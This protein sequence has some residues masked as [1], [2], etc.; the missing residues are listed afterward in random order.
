[1]SHLAS[2]HNSGH[3]DCQQTSIREC[4]RLLNSVTAV[5]VLSTSDRR[6]GCQKMNILNENGGRDLLL[7]APRSEHCGFQSDELSESKLERLK[8]KSPKSHFELNRPLITSGRC[9]IYRTERDRPPSSAIIMSILSISHSRRTCKICI[10]CRARGFLD[11][12]AFDPC[13]LAVAN[14]KDVCY[15]CAVRLIFLNFEVVSHEP[16]RREAGKGR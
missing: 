13:E 7:P 16:A 2:W 10:C 6:R 15:L 4:R 9:I 8:T 5:G 12:K 1:M 11:R 3:S 14:R